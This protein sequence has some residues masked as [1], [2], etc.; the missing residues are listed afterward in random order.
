MVTIGGTGGRIDEALDLRISRRDQHVEEPRNVGF[1]GGDRIFDRSRNTAQSGLMQHVIHRRRLLIAISSGKIHGAPAI[2]EVTDVSIDEVEVSPLLW[3]YQRL[4]FVQIALV[5][6][7]KVVQ[8]YHALIEFEQ[9][10]QQVAADET[11]HASDEPGF[12]IFAQF[13]LHFFKAGH[14]Q[15]LPSAAPIGRMLFTS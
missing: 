11:R 9:G 14:A 1:V 3:C 5:A 7:G 6:C 4:N 15:S 10:L 13:G 12:W 2:I 8:P